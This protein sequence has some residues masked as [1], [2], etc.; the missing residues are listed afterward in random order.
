MYL[1]NILIFESPEGAGSRVG[2]Y[3]VMKKI[4]FIIPC[5]N[6][7]ENVDRLHRELD[8]FSTA[9]YDVNGEKM[10][11]SR[12]EWEFLF[13]NDGSSDDTLQ[14]L[15][16]LRKDDKRVTVLNLTRNFGKESAMLA[17]M[18]YAGGDAV[19]NIDADLQDPLD[20]VPEM[21]YWWE[22]GYD[23]VYGKRLSRGKESRIRKVLSL[24]FYRML[25]R[26]SDIETL[27][28]VGDFRLL[29]RRAVRALTQLRETQRYMKGLYCWVGFNKKEVTFDRADREAGKSNFHLIKLLNL[30]IEG[31][32]SYTTSP[33]RYATVSGLLV[34]LCAFIYLIYMLVK[35]LV[36]GEVVAGFP[37]L[38]CVILFLGGMQL[39]ALGIIGEYIGRIFNETKGRP[40][41]MVESYNEE[42]DISIIE[43]VK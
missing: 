22:R 24:Y 27:P 6:E 25:N 5:H 16:E 29:D 20:V 36:W 21:I 2:G 15:R 19:I 37:T 28:N 34:S 13:I 33:L 38:I 14:K 1:Y 7:A 41:Y 23:D 32:T 17:G 10:D 12:F 11:M 39:L 18:D 43:E 42:R 30:A 31:I 3:D 35:T 8:R 4:S 40:P 26:M 9:V